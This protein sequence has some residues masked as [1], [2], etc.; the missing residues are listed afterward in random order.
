MSL[1]KGCYIGQEVIAR[2]DTY[3]KLQKRLMGLLL[4]DDSCVVPG[5]RV[6]VQERD[7]GRVTSVAQSPRL[8]RTI[9]LAYVRSAWAVPNTSVGVTTES[10][11]HEAQVVQLPFE[12]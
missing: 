1:T 9:A 3:K 5:A 7:V 10:G 2:L 4:G 8:N 12:V 6:S 11:T